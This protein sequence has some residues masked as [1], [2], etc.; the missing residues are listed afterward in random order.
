M[1]IDLTK[2]ACRDDWTAYGPAADQLEEAGDE[3]GARLARRQGE[4]LRAIVEEVT[5]AARS[6]AKR[7]VVS[8]V[9]PCRSRFVCILTRKLAI[10]R[11]VMPYRPSDPAAFGRIWEHRQTQFNLQRAIIA[12]PGRPEYLPSRVRELFERH[13]LGELLECPG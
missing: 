6:A 7:V 5:P 9:L 10:L 3:A 13:L 8:G 12:D 2:K 11:V 1:R 4:V